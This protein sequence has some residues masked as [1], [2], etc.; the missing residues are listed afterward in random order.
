MFEFSLL[1]NITLI[2]TQSPLFFLFIVALVSLSIGSFLN[3]VIYRLPVMMQNE[4]HH[5]CKLLLTDDL[6]KPYVN[7]DVKTF[8]L[9]TPA[10]TCPQCQSK[11]KAWQNIPVLSWIF[12]KGRCASC[13]N[14]IS[15]RYPSIELLT[16]ITSVVIAH[17]FGPTAISFTYLVVTWCL[18]ALI[19]IDID[20]MLLP[21]KS[22][23]LC[24][25]WL[26]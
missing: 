13:D 21:I 11:I 15:I 2:F 17:Y 1:Q 7:E 26:Y 3:V 6:K 24:F 9:A 19:F 4:W 23:Y 25:G 5:E 16:A 22:L 10:S 14:P 8:N 12:L 20:H 18:V